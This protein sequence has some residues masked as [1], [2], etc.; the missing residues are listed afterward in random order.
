[1]YNLSQAIYENSYEGINE[2]LRD[3]INNRGDK[4]QVIYELSEVLYQFMDNLDD[5]TKH[6]IGLALQEW[7]LDN[8][9]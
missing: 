9:L 3:M 4:Y 8:D 2:A 7:A 1:M 5:K 6:K